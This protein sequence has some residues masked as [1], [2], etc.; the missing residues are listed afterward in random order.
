M[1][2]PPPMTGAPMMMNRKKV[3]VVGLIAAGLLFL[4]IG[5]IL[6]DISHTVLAGTPPPADQVISYQ[7]LGLVWGPAVAHF[8]IFLFV[9]GLVAAALMLE[10]IDVFVRLFLLIV[11]FVALLL[12]LAGSKTIFG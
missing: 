6:V 11:S 1:Q 3:M 7:N 9:L 12:V 2:E 8:G 10:D 4:M 5:A